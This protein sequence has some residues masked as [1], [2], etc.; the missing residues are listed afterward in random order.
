MQVTVEFRKDV[1]LHDPISTDKEGNEIT[2]IKVFG[3]C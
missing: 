3:R 1:W 2:L